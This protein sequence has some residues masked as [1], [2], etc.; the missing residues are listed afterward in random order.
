MGVTKAKSVKGSLQAELYKSQEIKESVFLHQNKMTGETPEERW[1]EMQT[2]SELNSRIQKPFI[3]NVISPPS[4]YTQN[5][6]DKDWTDLAKDYA[7]KM[8]YNA[9]QWDAYLHKNTDNPHIHLSVNRVGT[10]GKTT[11]NDSYIGQK[12]QKV[13]QEIS[14]ER[15]WKNAKELTEDR[16]AEHKT[17]LL[18]AMQNS[19]SWQEV[20]KK[21]NSKGYHIELSE[22]ATGLTGA[23]IMELEEIR[24][25]AEKEEAT[26]IAQKYK[27]ALQKESYISEKEKKFSP[28]GFK[29]SE[30]DRKVKIKDLDNQLKNNLKKEQQQTKTQSYGRRI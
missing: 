19:S 12:S 24:K 7:E 23:R 9:N 27:T 2:I 29:L 16:K 5:F 10:E 25:R 20:E 4:Q 1:E 21:L 3:E 15:G 17:A 30:I 26:A 28:V 22:N 14:R 8:G 11:I 13:M 6:T 18:Y